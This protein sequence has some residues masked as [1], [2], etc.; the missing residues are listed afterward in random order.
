MNRP[1]RPSQAPPRRRPGGPPHTGGPTQPGPPRR[2][3][4][5]DNLPQGVTP[6]FKVL[7][8]MDRQLLVIGAEPLELV[9]IQGFTREIEET[10]QKSKDRYEDFWAKNPKLID[11]LRK[12]DEILVGIQ[13]RRNAK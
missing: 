12:L 13:A 8:T 6:P 9:V 3:S 5:L 1:R 2:R 7:G 11:T 4:P 10:Y